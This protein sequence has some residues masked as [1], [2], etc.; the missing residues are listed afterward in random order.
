MKPLALALV[1]ALASVAARAGTIEVVRIPAAALGRSWAADVYVPDGYARGSGR[2]DVLYLLHG[3]AGD[4]TQ[5]L[6]EGHIDRI[7]DALIARHAIPPCL[8]VMPSGGQ[9]WWVNG[10]EPMETAFTRD[11]IPAIDRR[12]RTIAARRGR[13][14]AGDSMGGFGALRLVM[15]H[16]GLFAA[17]AL[18]SPA[19]YVPTPPPISAARRAPPFQRNGHFSPALWRADNWPALLPGLERSDM[20]VPLFIASG[21]RDQMHI[22]VEARGLARVW[23]AHH[24]PVRLQL[25]DGRHSF[26]V[27]RLLAPDALRYIFGFAAPAGGL[28]AGGARVLPE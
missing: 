21:T 5:W 15:R 9:S 3:A 2:Y 11:L 16:P 19:I 1:L 26:R 27:W 17:A 6:R 12:Y 28:A 18:L 4:R 8:I 24:W 23:R 10:P 25:V 22:A 20:V 13:L 7:A 14:I